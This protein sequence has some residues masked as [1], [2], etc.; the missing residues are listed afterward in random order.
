MSQQ[1][2]DSIDAVLP[3]TQCGQCGFPGCRPY[4]VAIV[5]GHADIN[6]CP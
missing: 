2:I 1:L 6:Q 3:Q 5:E 4:A